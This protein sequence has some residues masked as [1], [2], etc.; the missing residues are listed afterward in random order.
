MTEGARRARQRG[1]LSRHVVSQRLPFGLEIAGCV[2]E[3]VF[4]C[5]G[6]KDYGICKRGRVD[7]R[8]IH[9]C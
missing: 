7:A 1:S 2:C 5:A 9:W 3:R 8:R 4:V 6:N